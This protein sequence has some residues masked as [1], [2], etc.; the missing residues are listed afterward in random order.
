MP[1]ATANLDLTF[2][3]LADPT[4]RD[5]VERLSRG[6]ATVSEIAEPYAMS[7]PAVVQH[8]A[9]LEASGLVRSEKIGRVRTCRIDTATL[10]LAEMWF[11]RRR[12]EWDQRLDR[13]G[14]HLK[15]FPDGESN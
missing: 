12:A 7:L 2:Q 8:L 5:I 11:N 14:E 13:L 6:Q 1:N 3:A 9:M 4:R 15:H 10:S